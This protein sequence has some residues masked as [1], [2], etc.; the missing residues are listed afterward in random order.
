MR[1]VRFR[2]LLPLCNLAIDVVLLAAMV[3]VA[4]SYFMTIRR[5]PP[6]WH[7][8]T[9]HHFDPALVDEWAFPQPIKAIVSGTLPAAVVPSLILPNGWRGSSPFDLWWACLHLA[10]AGSLWYGI[11][12][13]AEAGHPRLRKITTLFIALRALTIPGSLS[14]TSAG[15]WGV[16]CDLAM[17]VCWCAWCAAAVYL[18][19]RVSRYVIRRV[20]LY[21]MPERN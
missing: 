8:T 7:Q 13:F 21:W 5:A 11:G 2:W 15:S 10:F 12:R 9:G 19:A 18:V 1:G 6:L 20:R 16:L 14:L 4:H 17:I 3:W